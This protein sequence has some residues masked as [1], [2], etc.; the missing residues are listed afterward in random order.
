MALPIVAWF[1]HKMAND[2][3]FVK[4][5]QARFPEPK[6]EVLARFGCPFRIDISPDTLNML[7]ADTTI[8]DSLR[9]NGYKFLKQTADKYFEQPEGEGDPEGDPDKK[10]GLF[11]RLFGRRQEENNPDRNQQDQQ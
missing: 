11:D 4:M 6:P 9:A 7:L 10:R 2:R 1:W 8:R 3:K 5:Y